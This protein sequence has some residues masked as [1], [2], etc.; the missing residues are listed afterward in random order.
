MSTGHGILQC[1]SV[2]HQ[3]NAGQR[4]IGSYQIQN[5]IPYVEQAMRQH[6]VGYIGGHD[7]EHQLLAGTWV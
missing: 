7:F 1:P 6:D 4:G 2:L 5:S 3:L